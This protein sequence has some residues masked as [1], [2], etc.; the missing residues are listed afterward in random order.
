VS[1]D[2]HVAQVTGKS[3]LIRIMT[4]QTI[5]TVRIQIIAEW[6]SCSLGIAAVWNICNIYYHV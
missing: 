6:I 1:N 4:R 3:M 5:M 2:S